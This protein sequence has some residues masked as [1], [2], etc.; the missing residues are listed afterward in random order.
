MAKQIFN[1]KMY[2]FHRWIP[3]IIVVKPATVR[4]TA[5]N[6]SE[7]AAAHS[8]TRSTDMK[9]TVTIQI[10]DQNLDF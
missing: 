7:Q 9:Q 8:V 2:F 1:K 3:V 4:N 10:F 6:H 5:E